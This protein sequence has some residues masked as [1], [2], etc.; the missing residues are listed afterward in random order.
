MAKITPKE[1]FLK[2]AGGGRPE[3]VPFFTMTG[4]EVNPGQIPAT[5]RAGPAIFGDTRPSNPKNGKDM[6]GVT[7]V[8]TEETANASLPEPGNFLIKDITK[9]R[10]VIKAP[11]VEENIDWEA[12][13]KKDLER[14]KLDRSQSALVC[15]SGYQPFQQLMAFMGHSEGLIAMY[16]EPEA[17]KELQEF[18]INFM[19]PYYTKIIDYYKPDI[20]GITDDTCAEHDPFFSVEMYRE[21]FKP[22]YVRMAKVANDRGIPILFHICGRFEPFIDDMLDFGVQYAEPC[23]ETNNINALKA[24]YKGKL[25]FIGGFDWGKHVPKNYPNY[26]EEAYRQDI[27]NTY[28]K[29][30]KDG[31]WGMFGWPISYLG[32]PV[33][34]DMKRILWD[35]CEKYGKQVY[36]YKD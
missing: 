4:T 27:R 11:K 14:I 17:I 6:W 19:E 3:Y 31:G 30:S 35:E 18:M 25:S 13:A 26:D 34:D 33:N 23:Q 20:W 28:D 22:V 16:E 21:F 29:Y 9:W 1:N 36:G 12:L 2:L 32:D 24:Q 7:Y 8:A 10:D 15:A 5:K